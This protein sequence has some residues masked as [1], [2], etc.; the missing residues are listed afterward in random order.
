MQFVEKEFSELQ[1]AIIRNAYSQI[2]SGI[3][4]I[5]QY[6]LPNGSTFIIKVYHSLRDT[7]QLLGA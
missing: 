6:D 1:G 3:N 2:V 7:L 5:I 4:F